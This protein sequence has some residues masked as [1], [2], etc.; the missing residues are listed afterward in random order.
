MNWDRGRNQYDLH[1]VVRN[2][3]VHCLPVAEMEQIG[4]KVVDHFT[5]RP[6]PPYEAAETMADVR[7]G[8][9][10]ARSL[11]QIGDMKRAYDMID[12]KLTTPLWF[13]LER[14]DEYLVLVRPYFPDGWTKP[15]QGLESKGSLGILAANAGVALSQLG[16]TTD[17]L[18]VDQYTI[19][20]AVREKSLYSLCNRLRNHCYHLMNAA[21]MEAAERV[22]LL[23]EEGAAMSNEEDRACALSQR[24]DYLMDLG[25]LTEAEAALDRL[26]A[27]PRP[28]SRARYRLGEVETNLVRL[29]LCQNRLN[30]DVFSVAMLAASEG[31]IEV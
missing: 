15:P 4:R 2:Y 14:Y 28:T 27:G 8:L 13:N 24:V 16:R 17:A 20:D 22:L 31:K 1:P 12:D 29:R 19:P 9:Q 23:E 26:K 18:A 6:D 10:V 11:V 25:R 7:N 3:A 21:R 30:E 5:S